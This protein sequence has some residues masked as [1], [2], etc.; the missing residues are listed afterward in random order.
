[1]LLKREEGGREG[2]REG[3]EKDGVSIEVYHYPQ[4]DE[5]A[6]RSHRVQGPDLCCCKEKREGGREGGREGRRMG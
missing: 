4:K 5:R 2:G 3:G 1:V 6:G